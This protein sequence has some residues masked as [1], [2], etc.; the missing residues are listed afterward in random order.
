MAITV[1]A[2]CRAA[3]TA[4]NPVATPFGP[5]GTA[6]VANQ[7]SG[8]ASV[9]DLASGRSVAVAVGAGPTRWPSRQTA[10]PA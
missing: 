3:T 10:V 1:L 5:V 2:A 6:L 8:S 7:Q 4:V 9:V